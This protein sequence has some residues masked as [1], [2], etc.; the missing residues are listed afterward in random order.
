[1]R[2]TMTRKNDDDRVIQ[3]DSWTRYI[4]RHHVEGVDDV[5]SVLDEGTKR[6][7]TFPAFGREV[8][9]RLF[10][11]RS[12]RVDRVRPEDA[13]QA[14]A[15]DELDQL[16]SW[17][18]LARRATGDRVLAAAA[19]TA[20]AEKVLAHFPPP[21]EPVVDA[22]PLRQRA[23]GLAALLRDGNGDAAELQQLLDSV[24]AR[25]QAAV[26]SA[27]AYATAL[28]DSVVRDA[29]REGL[30][31]AHAE[32]D[33]LEAEVGGY[34]GWG[35]GELRDGGAV[36]T[37]AHI[38]DALKQSEKLR[39][40]GVLA[41]RMRRIA[42]LKRRSRSAHARDEVSE[43]ER[44]ND[45][46]RVLPSELVKLTDPVAALVFARSFVEGTLAQYRL[47]GRERQG[48][49][50]VVVC[51]DSSGSMEGE[52]E[53][54]SKAIALALLQ[55]AVTDKR[56][57]RIV[58]FDDDVR[59][60]DDFAPGKVQPAAVM[61]AMVPFF[62]GGTNFELPLSSAMEAIESEAELRQADVVLITDGEAK[63]S[64]AFKARWADARRRH[65]VTVFA[66][67]IGASV[68]A[69]LNEIADVVIDVNELAADNA[70][71]QTLAAGVG[72]G[73]AP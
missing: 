13:W 41:G 33:R 63:M 19:A 38:A 4:W 53:V 12:E 6:Y 15:H 43:V 69:V 29:L 22:E 55:L 24:R 45:L 18:A 57:C 34:S 30:T 60:V 59:R 9:G 65:E 44:G 3:T 40:L 62:G 58:Q 61:A 16:P 17:E 56:R 2:C 73:G 7:D 70:A 25:G 21:A 23:R 47:H 71:L 51:V 14:R 31:A 37:K 67:A 11:A 54:W 35:R 48:R 52:P 28:D 42:M 39:K 27:M 36:E 66:V 8:F 26:A 32:L 50:P 46:S 20:L 10:S 5:K 1:M 68:P 49:G 64:E 72:N